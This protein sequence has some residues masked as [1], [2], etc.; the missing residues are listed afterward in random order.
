MAFERSLSIRLFGAL[1]GFVLVASWVF[2]EFE[3]RPGTAGYLSYREALEDILILVFSGFDVSRRPVTPQGYA[4][5]ISV[6]I[7]GIGFVTVLMGNAAAL[8]FK[9]ALN[10]DKGSRRIKLDGHILICNWNG[11][12]RSIVRQLLS[13]EASH[14]SEIVIVADLE[15]HPYPDSGVHFVAGSPTRDEVLTRACVE[16]AAT[17]IITGN[18]SDATTSDSLAILTALAVES[19]NRD[20]YTCVVV[21]DPENKKH[22]YHA[23][24]DEVVCVSEVTTSMLAHSALNHGLTRLI[25]QLLDFGEG[26]E[27]YK[28]VLPE[29]FHGMDFR[30]AAGAM[31]SVYGASLVGIEMAGPSGDGERRVVTTPSEVDGIAMGD[32]GFIVAETLPDGL[33]C[34]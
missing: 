17:A 24:V 28:V 20:V 32:C 7:A 19:R 23:H 27:I 30:G 10:Q 33:R 31:L 11:H 16:G 5:A 6:L 8:L 14:D 29:T 9:R 21:F 34:Q 25:S 13:D 2:Y 18:G 3:S 12:G 4:A 15:D 26:S 22:L 1:V